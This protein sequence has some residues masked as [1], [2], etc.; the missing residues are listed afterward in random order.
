[1]KTNPWLYFGPVHFTESFSF[2]HT[3]LIELIFGDLLG[4][5]RTSSLLLIKINAV[6]SI[7]CKTQQR[8]PLNDQIKGQGSFLLNFHFIKIPPIA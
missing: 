8:N 7:K 5:E 3:F 1:M 2:L 6:S 4:K